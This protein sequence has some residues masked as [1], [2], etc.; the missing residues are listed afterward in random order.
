MGPGVMKKS[1]PLFT[2]Y[3]GWDWPDD[4]MINDLLQLSR[5]DQGREALNMKLLI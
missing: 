1:P 5:M 4:P 2:G 3:P